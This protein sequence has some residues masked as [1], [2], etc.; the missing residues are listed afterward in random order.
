M[1]FAF[2]LILIVMNGINRTLA[3]LEHK[4]K[5]LCYDIYLLNNKIREEELVYLR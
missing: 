2:I 4:Q 5:I 3:S 1:I